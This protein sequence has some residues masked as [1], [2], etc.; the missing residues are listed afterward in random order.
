MWNK[1]SDSER[2]DA[3]TAWLDAAD[4]AYDLYFHPAS[5]TIE[6]AKRHWLS[7]IHI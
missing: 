6:L 4:I 5:P 1:P 3:V 7:L 2:I